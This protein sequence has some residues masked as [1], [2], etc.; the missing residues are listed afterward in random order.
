MEDRTFYMETHSRDPY[1]NLAFE[2]YVLERRTTG[3]Y[4]LLW[5]NDNTVVIGLNQNAEEEI[6]RAFVEK[7]AIRVVRRMTGGGAVYHDLG[8]LNYSFISDAGERGQLSFRRFVL[9][10]VDAL[11]ELGLPA[12]TSGRNDI[13]IDGKKVSG[14]AQRLLRGRI[15][16]HGTLLF[17]SD[18][19]MIAGALR[20]DP[21]KFASKSSKSVRGRVGNIRDFLPEDMDLPTFWAYLREKL[22]GSGIIQAQLDQEDLRAVDALKQSKY[23]SW[24]WNFGKSPPCG[25]TNRRRWAGGTLDV[26][27]SVAEGRIVDIIFYGD[28]L[29][30]YPLSQL[31]RELCG[32]RFRKEDIA[33]IL[34]RH[35][36]ELYFGGISMDQIMSTIFDT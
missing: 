20:A 9:P 16:H 25:I 19:H 17:D 3:S 23:N 7:H 10:V 34:K 31:T 29:S 5:Q 32:C 35:P 6:N 27:L 28:F 14:T 13:L 21:A 30:L 2:E 36:L 22:S 8:N 24:D 26:R 15:L 1:Y 12:E 11:R 33:R 4:L 18:P